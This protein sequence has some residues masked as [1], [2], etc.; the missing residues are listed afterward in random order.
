MCGGIRMDKKCGGFKLFFLRFTLLMNL[1][2]VLKCQNTI[3][4]KN[5]RKQNIL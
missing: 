5:L 1:H 2:L 3:V 4:S